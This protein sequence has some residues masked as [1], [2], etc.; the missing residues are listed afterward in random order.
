[1]PPP[2]STSLNRTKIVTRYEACPSRAV[3]HVFKPLN[4]FVALSNMS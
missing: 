3:S 1:M 2:F 4:T